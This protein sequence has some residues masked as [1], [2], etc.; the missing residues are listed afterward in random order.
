MK[1]LTKLGKGYYSS[2]LIIRFTGEKA[3]LLRGASGT[4]SRRVNRLRSEK[5]EIST[6]LRANT[7]LR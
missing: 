5:R 1:L 2:E 4:S 6:L 7:R 3:A